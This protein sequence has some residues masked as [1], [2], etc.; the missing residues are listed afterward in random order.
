M[1]RPRLFLFAIVVTGGSTAADCAQSS[2]TIAREETRV[3][4][5][6]L[7]SFFVRRDTKLLVLLDSTIRGSNHFVDEDY[8]RALNR[9]GDLPEGLQ[10]DFA[11]KRNAR[12]KLRD[13]ST[14][15][16]V[17]FVGARDLAEIRQGAT[18]PDVFWQRFYSRF[19]ASSGRLA[20]SR[21]GFSRDG[22]YAL[23]LVDY[24]CGGRCGGTV[25]YLLER[26]ADMWQTIRV[27]QPRI[28]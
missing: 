17:V 9:L 16:P 15:V 2:T 6:V 23:M 13:M 19:P 28:S 8:A 26:R 11:K 3:Q 12:E 7:D 20:V 25:Y 21:L 5:A 22:R 10:E 14:R 1:L 4:A 18:N 24:G 27:A